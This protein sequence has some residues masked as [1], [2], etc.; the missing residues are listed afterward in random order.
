MN[1]S[2]KIAMVGVVAAAALVKWKFC[3]HHDPKH[4]GKIRQT[5]HARV[6]DLRRGA[7]GKIWIGAHAAFTT[8]ETDEVQH[9]PVG[10]IEHVVLTLVDSSQKPTPLTVGKW[11]QSG[12][13]L[14]G[15]LALPDVPDGDYQLHVAF[16]THLGAAA[17]DIPIPLYTPARIHVITDR[18]LYEPGNTVH[19]RAVVLRARDLAPLD[20]R[21]GVWVVKDPDGEILLE[22]KAPAGD[23][24]VVA[25]TFPLDKKAAVGTWH[26]AW[27][28]A[29][30]TTDIPFTVEPFVL[31]RFRVEANAD[32]PFYQ[33]SD[34]PVIRGA[35]V[36][37]SGA[38][39]AKA[40]L[41][42][43]WDITGAWPPP[44]EWQDK[45]LPK[46]AITGDNGRFE[47]A[48]PKIPADLQGQVT[49]SARI[50]AIDPA[51]DRVEGTARV[52]LS[53]DAIQASAV[54][55]LGGLVQGFNNRLYVR[56]ATADGRPLAST[57]IKVKRAWQADD[58]G[59]DAD[60]DE[61]GVASLQ[62]DPGPPVNIV[63]PPA[64]WRPQPKAALVARGE[65]TELIGGEGAS[66][67][68]QVEMD[69]WLAALA[70][71][72]KWFDNGGEV[73]VALHVDAGGGIVGAS[74]GGS[75]IDRCTVDVIKSRRL[76]A[77]AERMYTVD[78][79]YTDPE[80]SKLEASVESALEAP[81]GLTE[82][83]EELAHGARDCLPQRGTE[84]ALPVALSWRSHAGSKTVELGGWFKDPKGGDAASAV[85]CV[86]AH[87]TGRVTLDEAPADDS[88]GFIRFSLA[89]PAEL[90]QDKP[91]ATTM[92]GYELLIT[93]DGDGKPHTK[94]RVTPG[95][96]PN[97]RLRVSPVLPK[98]GETLTA[99][100]IRGPSF[101]GKL[102]EELD[103]TCQKAKS[104]AKVNDEHT[105]KL[106]ID[107]K[108]EGWCQIGGHGAPQALVYVRPQNEL[109]VLL[110]AKKER[111]APGDK[112]EL[113]IQTK[114]GGAGREAAVGLIGVDQSLGQ[115]VTL[116]EAGELGKLQPTV[117]TSQPA[118]GVLDGQAL[119]LGRIRGA[120]AAAA[121]VLRVSSIPAPP[122]LDAVVNAQA[123]TPFDPVIELT[124]HFYRV[125]AELNVQARKW[126][127]S[128]P[129]NEKM[130]P[131][132]LASLW[133]QAL[134][135]CEKRGEPIDDA[136]GRRLRL[137]LLPE[138]LLAL[139]DPRV[140]VVVGTR[141]PEDV[142]N[143]SEWVRKE[144]P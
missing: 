140:V 75:Q 117:G 88:L 113:A 121:T 66:L 61:D 108:V 40:G 105:A 132:T 20:H 6:S 39:V 135:A 98:P 65:P 8:H 19:F 22:E 126:E 42:I 73:K 95:T 110:H 3:G 30:A 118:F 89:L 37:S 79:T 137:S 62:F 29:D 139:T 116:P 58:P 33:A 35:V 72:A 27:T 11:E 70:P 1:R 134:D 2:A 44:P 5:A 109:E 93:A 17:V 119:T 15:D 125:L 123:E 112:A 136:Y 124:D 74:G 50:A 85:A 130:H 111:Y 101:T 69:K 81:N 78:F 54:T 80:I 55:E 102:P 129:P 12:A 47:L 87:V 97:L 38:P 133:N 24:G 91:Q 144:K 25:G 36:Y 53:E 4:E 16:E 99:Q 128:A 26:V 45:L 9:E 60:L 59:T 106:T 127:V 115:L 43:T 92:L 23:W 114:I 120:N 64:P 76:S 28:S 142:E 71:C 104:T 18:P 56:V 34:H 96:V 82:K 138:D 90:A 68:D 57:K 41:D 32:K 7:T 48:L 83:I 103:L 94:L 46:K 49:V 84:G 21:P 14:G 52:L 122:E 31:P 63:I 13:M 143:W 131:A 77:G 107:A 67:A 51:G 10:D 141:L 86:Q 100:L